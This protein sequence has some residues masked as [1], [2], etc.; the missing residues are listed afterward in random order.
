MTPNSIRKKI[1]PTRANSAIVAPRRRGVVEA[2]IMRQL[3]V[4]GWSAAGRQGSVSPVFR[5]WVGMV[6][7]TTRGT[8]RREA[9]LDV[10][11]M[12]ALGSANMPIAD[13]FTFL[14]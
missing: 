12:V 2:V 11:V 10:A 6:V 5:G 14:H 7:D 13:Q 9:Q 8:F 3:L 4:F 1:G